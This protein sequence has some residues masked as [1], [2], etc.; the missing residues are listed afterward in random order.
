[1]ILH[2]CI[3]LYHYI[4]SIL[5]LSGLVIGASLGLRTNENNERAI[6][7]VIILLLLL[8]LI[9]IQIMLMIVIVIVIVIVIIV[10]ILVLVLPNGFVCGLWVKHTF[11]TNTT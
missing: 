4:G 2:Y 3:I 10:F 6:L 7:V 1:M 5:V 9:I 8:L 11:S